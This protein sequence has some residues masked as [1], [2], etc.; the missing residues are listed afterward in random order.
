MMRWKPLLIRGDTRGTNGWNGIYKCIHR[1]Y[2]K[3]W[4]EQ[5]H[6]GMSIDNHTLYF[7]LLLLLYEWPFSYVLALL[8]SSNIH[9][10]TTTLLSGSSKK[11]SHNKGGWK[12]HMYISCY[13]KTIFFI[14]SFH[15]LPL[16][17]IN[18]FRIMRDNPVNQFHQQFVASQSHVHCK[19]EIRTSSSYILLYVILAL[20]SYLRLNSNNN[21]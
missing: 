20:F 12:H 2:W 6:R 10:P 4:K 17:S 14:N 13:R 7:L 15:T 18:Q 11:Q 5:H 8:F 3:R 21:V 19:R 16:F 1:W 9:T